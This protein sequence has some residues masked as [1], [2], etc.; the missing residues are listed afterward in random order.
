VLLDQCRQRPRISDDARARA[1]VVMTYAVVLIAVTQGSNIDG[2][3]NL[4][5]NT[6]GV[7]AANVNQQLISAI[8]K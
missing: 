2:V 8:I 1:V 4:K 6:V 3:D 5:G 7:I